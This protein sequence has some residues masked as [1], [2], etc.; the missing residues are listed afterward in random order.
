MYFCVVGFV[1]LVEFISVVGFVFVFLDYFFVKWLLFSC[2]VI[3]VCL[4]GFV[5]ML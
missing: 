1:F 3:Y 5:F 2:C 4:V